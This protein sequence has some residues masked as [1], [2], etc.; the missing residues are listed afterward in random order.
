MERANR[1]FG[2][3]TIG[4]NYVIRK[5]NRPWP[6]RL[7]NFAPSAFNGCVPNGHDE[8]HRTPLHFLGSQPNRQHCKSA[9]RARQP[10]KPVVRNNG[11]LGPLHACYIEH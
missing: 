9:T 8:R 10:V 11:I 4:M 2:L 3:T 7:E 1:Q 6:N 5:N